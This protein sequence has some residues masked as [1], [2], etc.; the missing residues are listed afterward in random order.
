M[1]KCNFN[2]SI[3]LLC[4]F[5]EIALRHGCSPINLLHIFRTRFPKNTSEGQPLKWLLSQLKQSRLTLFN[6]C[7]GKYDRLS[8]TN[9]PPSLSSTFVNNIREKTPG[10]PKIN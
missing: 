10:V 2:N 1:P 3:K 9:E 5:I 6:S 4:N 7:Y 8:I